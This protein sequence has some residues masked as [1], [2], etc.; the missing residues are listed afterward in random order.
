MKL[1]E[2]F[3]M[4][5][6]FNKNV[7][8]NKANHEHEI[9]YEKIL[10]LQVKIAEMANETN[11]FKYCNLQKNYDKNVLIK[12]YVDCLHFIISLGLDNKFTPDEIEFKKSTLNLTSQFEN[13]YIDINDF[14]VC[15][16]YDHYITLIE[17]YLSLGSSF[18]FS[19][20]EILDVCLVK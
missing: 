2:L 17:D 1:S 12:K 6:S 13:L 5:D 20:R 18:G 10:A 19:E 15:S 7:L 4:Q 16:S 9:K 11:C 14:V 3:N 8:K